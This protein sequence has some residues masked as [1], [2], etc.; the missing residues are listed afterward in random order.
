LYAKSRLLEAGVTARL[1][2]AIYLNS[3]VDRHYEGVFLMILVVSRRSKLASRQAAALTSVRERAKARESEQ[4][5][6]IG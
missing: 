3:L 2:S 1:S 4:P 5:G 6:L